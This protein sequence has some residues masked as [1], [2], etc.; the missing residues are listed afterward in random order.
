MNDSSPREAASVEAAVVDVSDA[1]ANVLCSTPGCPSNWWMFGYSALHTGY[2]TAELGVPPAIGQWDATIGSGEVLPPACAEDGRAFVTYGTNGSPSLLVAVSIADGSTLWSHDFGSPFS[3]GH[4][5]V[6][7]GTVY[8]QTN[9]GISNIPESKLWAFDAMNG[10]VSWSAPFASQAE[11][12]W[13]PA[14][15]GRGV[16]INGGQYGGLYGF[17]A[18]DGTRLFF[19]DGFPMCDS[20]TPAFQSGVLYSYVQGSF[21]AS[22]PSTGSL[23]WNNDL[24][25]NFEPYSMNATAALDEQAAYLISPPQL[26]ALDLVTQDFR[27]IVDANYAGTPAIADGVVYAVSGGA[28]IAVS[29]STGATS[30]EF[31]GDAALSYPPVLANG[32]AYVSS[33]SNVYAVSTVSLQQVWTAPVGGWLSVASGH[34]LV[35]GADGVL[36][37]FALATPVAPGD[38]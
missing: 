2:N 14:V 18:I 13:G 23:L 22:D 36:H 31:A 34:L 5:S 4:A 38:P 10:S 17:D 28:L 35:A 29:A 8:V 3:L 37:G 9:K 15:G 19:N 21:V 30:S 16:Y 33:A 7:N 24:R 1:D 25:G 11:N 12:F 6:V 27:W 32:F 26:A 20:W